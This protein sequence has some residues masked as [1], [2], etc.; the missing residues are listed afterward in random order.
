M[1][2]FGFNVGKEGVNSNR[3]SSGQWR[4]QWWR[5]FYY[6]KYLNFI[7]IIYILNHYNGVIGNRLMSFWN[8][9]QLTMECG[10]L[11]TRLGPPSDTFLLDTA[12]VKLVGAMCLTFKW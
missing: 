2:G 6:R 9:F 11:Q 1:N 12:L 4:S 5:Q 3:A 7:T 8:S 10:Q